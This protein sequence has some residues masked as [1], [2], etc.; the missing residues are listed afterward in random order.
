V[1]NAAIN[2]AIDADLKAII[3]AWPDPPEPIKA[4][5]LA[6]LTDEVQTT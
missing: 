1:T 2:A 4:R 6:M 3:D 5:I